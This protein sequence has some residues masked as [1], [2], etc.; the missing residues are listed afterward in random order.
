[1]IKS[2]PKKFLISRVVP[3]LVMRELMGKCAYANLILNLYPYGLF[4]Q[5][6]GNEYLSDTSDHVFNLRRDGR[7][8]SL[9]LSLA[10]PH[11]ESN[12]S[13]TL[14]ILLNFLDWER[15]VLKASDNGASF[16]FNGDFSGLEININWK[17]MIW[18]HKIK[19]PP[20]GT[21]TSSSVRMYFIAKPFSYKLKF[22]LRFIV[23]KSGADIFNHN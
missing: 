17:V 4:S 14:L 20:S 10:Q 9:L 2:S 11:L 22:Y 6:I 13:N 8:A 3:L 1:M 16:S 18:E 12:F 21:V 5:S 19:V 7:N 15:D 23:Q